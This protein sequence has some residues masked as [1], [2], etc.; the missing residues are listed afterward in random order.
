MFAGDWFGKDIAEKELSCKICKEVL[1]FDIK[2]L[3]NLLRTGK[4][5]VLWYLWFCSFYFCLHMNF[6]FSYSMKIV[7]GITWSL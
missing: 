1:N 3:D 4:I 2:N 6:R 5:P 7:M